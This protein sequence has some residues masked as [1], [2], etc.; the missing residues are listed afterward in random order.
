MTLADLLPLFAQSGVFGVM[1][2]FAYRL[3][4]SAVMAHERR[5]TEWYE[6]WKAERAYSVERERQ[7]AH[8]LAAVPAAATGNSP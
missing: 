6:T 2:F 8:I 3:H 4:R 1:A 7:L 5:A